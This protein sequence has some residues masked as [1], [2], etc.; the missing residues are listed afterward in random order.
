MSESETA[1]KITELVK[2]ADKLVRDTRKN[3]EK[4]LDVVRKLK[5]SG[6]DGE[7]SKTK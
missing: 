2:A 1:K 3:A 5:E 6:Q 7:E 4:L